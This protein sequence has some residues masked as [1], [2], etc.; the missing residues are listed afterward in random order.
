[1]QCPICHQPLT[2]P[3][4]HNTTQCPACQ[5]SLLRSP[6][7]AKLNGDE[8]LIS[9]VPLIAV[10]TCIFMVLLVPCLF[11]AES[12]VGIPSKITVLAILI[13]LLPLSFALGWDGL[14]SLK[15]G[16]DKTKNRLSRGPEAR[17]TGLSKI[18]LGLGLIGIAIFGLYR[19]SEL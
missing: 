6:P 8:A 11:L 12:L 10:L 4:R 19:I 15:T 13:L 2:R 3:F 1:M 9:F 7:L 5:R 14:L 17:F 16:I 18:V